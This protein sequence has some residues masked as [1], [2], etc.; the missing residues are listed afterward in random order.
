[1]LIFYRILFLTAVFPVTLFFSL[2]CYAIGKLGYK[3]LGLACSRVW[4][5][6]L[7]FAAGVRIKV[8][9][10]ALDPK[11]QY[12]FMANHLSQFD[13]PVICVALSRYD[14]IYMAKDTLFKIP[15]FGPA[16][17]AIGHVPVD[18]SNRRAAMAS[19]EAMVQ[20]ARDG[21]NLLVFPEGSR[22]E[23]PSDLAPFKTGGVITALKAARP[24]VPVVVRGSASILPKKSL[25][26]TP[27]T[28]EIICLPPFDP[29]QAYTLKDRDRLAEDLRERMR[30]VYLGQTAAQQGS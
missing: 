18:R 22:N 15:F 7:L 23:D 3:R 30:R 10:S 19:V 6:V 4:A 9:Q 25:L 26:H 27:G 1:M 14:L 21:F 13:I 11:G 17:L 5:R 29:S 2:L 20:A 8:D 12:V 24:I 28:V 16:L